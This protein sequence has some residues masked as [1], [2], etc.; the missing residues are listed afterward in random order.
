MLNNVLKIVHNLLDITHLL[1]V[2]FV[3]NNVVIVIF[4]LIK[5]H[6]SNLVV[7]MLIII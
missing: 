2:L 3:F 7:V 1:Q 6:V 5:N 4:H